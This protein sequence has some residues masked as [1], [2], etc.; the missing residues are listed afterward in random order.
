MV[1]NEFHDPRGFLDVAP[2]LVFPSDTTVPGPAASSPD[3]FWGR[4]TTSPERRASLYL[5]PSESWSDAAT[6]IDGRDNNQLFTYEN[7]WC[8]W[9]PGR[10]LAALREI[11][12]FWKP[13]VEDGVWMVNEE[14]VAGGMGYSTIYVA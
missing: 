6:F 3:N 10:P 4:E 1:N 8:P 7:R 11:L 9:M 5:S 2:T 12:T 14:G 13:L